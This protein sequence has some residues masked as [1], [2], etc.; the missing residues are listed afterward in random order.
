MIAAS[1]CSCTVVVHIFFRGQGQVPSILRK[2]FLEILA[3][4]FCM[5]N[6]PPGAAAAAE[7]QAK[8]QQQASLNHTLNKQGNYTNNN[9]FGS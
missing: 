8:L 6:T 9:C 2:I 1:T 7:A 3:R 4:I 5:V